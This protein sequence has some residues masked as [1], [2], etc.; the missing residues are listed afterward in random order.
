M[1]DIAGVREVD[2]DRAVAGSTGAFPSA[3]AYLHMLLTDAVG[4]PVFIAA[5]AGIATSGWRRAL[6]LV[7]FPLAFLAFVSHTVPE[8]RYLNVLLP[9]VAVAGAAG[10]AWIVRRLGWRSTVLTA[11]VFAAAALPGLAGGIRSDR[12]FMQDDTRT[13]AARYILEHVP[14]GATILVQP[15]SVP[16]N[17]SRESIVEALRLH[18]GSEEHASIKYRLQLAATPYPSPA[19]RLIYLGDGGLDPD[20][21]YLSPKAFTGRDLAPLQQLGVDYVV[22]KRYNVPNPDLASLESALGAHAKRIASVS[23]YREGAGAAE[24][25][26]TAPFLHNTAARIEPALERPGPIVDIWQIAK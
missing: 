19:Y 3:G 7:S 17:R 1:R 14:S 20:R 13:V 4:W 5:F 2:I 8:S 21:I 11:T 12:F 23:P 9:G 26:S 24:R 22:L 18:L 15:Y 10:V 6:L 16:L 25:A